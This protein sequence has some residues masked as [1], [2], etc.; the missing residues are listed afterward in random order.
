MDIQGAVDNFYRARVHCDNIVEVHRAHGGGNLGRRY[1]EVSL[2]RA[3]VVLAVA[4]WQAAVQDMTSA[5]LDTAAPTSGAALDMARYRIQVGPVRKGIGD[6]GTPN[7]KNTRD[8]MVVAGFDPRPFWTYSI[9][10]G[11]GRG[12][13]LWTPKM[14]DDRVDEWLKVRHAVAH[15]HETMPIVRAL[16]AVRQDPNVQSPTIRLVDAEQCVSFFT[17]LVRLTAEPIAAQLGAPLQLP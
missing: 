14:V 17:R 16:E 7:A 12:R 15:G 10:G 6:F 8:L 13:E 1:R 2:D 11:R 4:A 5:M 3:V 9:M